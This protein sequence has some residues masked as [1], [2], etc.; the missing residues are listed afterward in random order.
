MDLN[1]VRDILKPF[2]EFFGSLLASGVITTYATQLA[3][4][5][6]IAIPAKKYPR[7]V[8]ASLS[9][10]I[11]LIAYYATSLNIVVNSAWAWIAM[12]VG[13]FLVSSITYRLVLKSWAEAPKTK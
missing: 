1:A 4:A 5:D 13:S 12:A 11:T 3:K 2:V 9:A 10:I 8:A 7:S 6:W